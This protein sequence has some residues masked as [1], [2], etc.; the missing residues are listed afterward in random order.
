MCMCV[1]MCMCACACVCAC[2]CACACAC[3]CVHAIIP[4]S[5]GGRGSRV[6]DLP[7]KSCY[8]SLF[9]VPLAAVADLLVEGHCP[10]DLSVSWT[11]LLPGQLQGP[12]ETSYYSISYSTNQVQTNRTEPFLNGPSA[13]CLC[14][15]VRVCAY[16]CSPILTCPGVV[17]T[18][19]AITSSDYHG[20]VCLV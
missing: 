16:T 13:V 10:S 8:V 9:V 5:V 11:P 18:P 1:C 20:A 14:V 2:V 12:M 19:V 15:C 3:V 4:T 17:G 6:H 7:L